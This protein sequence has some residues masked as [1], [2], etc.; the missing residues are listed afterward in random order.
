LSETSWPEILPQKNARRS[1]PMLPPT[2]G[3]QKVGQGLA[4]RT[5]QKYDHGIKL[6]KELAE[7][8]EVTADQPDH[9]IVYGQVF[10]PSAVEALSK[11]PGRDGQ[12]TAVKASS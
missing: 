11:K 4:P 8:L 6:L 3:R 7:E 9:A 5:L 1:S 2:S 10:A 12:N